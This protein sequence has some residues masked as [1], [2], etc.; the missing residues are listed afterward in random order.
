MEVV[1]HAGH[2]GDGDVVRQVAVGA[3]QPAARRALAGG[4]EMSDLPARVNAGIRPPGTNHLEFVIRNRRQ[5]LLEALLHADAG[6]LALP[7]VV[8]GT[9]VLDTDRESHARRVATGAR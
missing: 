7:A 4:I 8:R 3:E 2:P 1:G 6:F 5:R 9:V